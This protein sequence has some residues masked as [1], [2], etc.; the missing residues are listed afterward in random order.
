MEG[1]VLNSL[2]ALIKGETPL[3]LYEAKK[4]EI[5]NLL[6]E[7]KY[8][9]YDVSDLENE[10]HSIDISND[11]TIDRILCKLKV[12]R[13]Y[14]HKIVVLKYIATS[15]ES[16]TY[17]LIDLKHRY[18][19]VLFYMR[20][21]ELFITQREESTRRLLYEVGYK[22]IEKEIIHTSRS[23]ILNEI[24]T[25]DYDTMNLNLIIIDILEKINGITYAN[26]KSLKSLIDLIS[27]KKEQEDF[28]SYVDIDII[29]GIIIVTN[30]QE[31]LINL[32]PSTK[33][34]LNNLERNVNSL[35]FYQGFYI[36]V[37][38]VKHEN[39]KRVKYIKKI[40]VKTVSGLLAL[41]LLFGLYNF[42]LS[43]SIEKDSMLY[44]VETTVYEDSL[45]P[46]TTYEVGRHEKDTLVLEVYKNEVNDKGQTVR[47]KYT[48]DEKKLKNIPIDESNY[49]TI[50]LTGIKESKKEGY[51]EN[52]T[53]TEEKVIFRIITADKEEVLSIDE[54][55]K[56]MRII[57]L[58]ATWI[59]LSFI[60]N[61]FGNSIIC[62]IINLIKYLKSNKPFKALKEQV[63][64]EL[65]EITTA[66]SKS[67]SALEE[68]DRLL[69]LFEMLSEV[70]EVDN[71]ELLDYYKKELNKYKEEL[72]Y[73][74]K[75]V[76]EHK[77]ELKLGGA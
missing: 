8:N 22:L 40:K 30:S 16:D 10:Y 48:Y 9:G 43:K 12:I 57:S 27:R 73:N 46:V 33:D 58:W 54:D 13:M 3:K 29:T 49:Q 42:W 62:I 77:K 45:E 55:Y 56:Q 2:E 72:S 18:F 76:E 20:N 6:K 47:Y 4:M 23:D 25:N 70:E 24:L 38:F 15:L 51:E 7:I 64:K 32:E 34:A 75:G 11:I 44:N 1:Q 35:Q 26:P 17:D 63:D 69:K 50:D 61:G 19:G 14:S 74:I 60:P 66:I 41:G 68:Y 71:Q 53:E 52:P 39:E 36:T 21:S 5:D 28:K 31:L 37:G 67:E 65:V 59:L